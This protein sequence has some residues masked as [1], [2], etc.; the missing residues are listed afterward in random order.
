MLFTYTYICM[1]VYVVHTETHS[2]SMFFLFSD[3]QELYRFLRPTYPLCF[4]QLPSTFQT[5]TSKQRI[6]QGTVPAAVTGP[7]LG[8]QSHSVTELPVL[9]VQCLPLNSSAWCFLNLHQVKDVHRLSAIETVKTPANLLL[10]EQ[11]TSYSVQTPIISPVNVVFQYAGV[12]FASVYV[13][14]CKSI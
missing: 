7:V 5:L 13:P 3:M 6:I 1:Y 2:Y 14:S 8:Q 9:F 12:G 4:S 11:L 10:S